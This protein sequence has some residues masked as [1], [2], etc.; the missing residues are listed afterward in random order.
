MVFALPNTEKVLTQFLSR[1]S[2][3]ADK[4][5]PTIFER[6]WVQ[7]L[8]LIHSPYRPAP[9]SQLWHTWYHR[10]SRISVDAAKTCV[11]PISRWILL[12]CGEIQALTKRSCSFSANKRNSVPRRAFHSRDF[13][14]QRKSSEK[15][16]NEK[17]PVVTTQWNCL[18]WRLSALLMW[19]H[20]ERFG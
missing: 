2:Q 13:S 4:R 11:P 6:P 12:P 20:G 14:F 9:F 18:S 15:W 19:A 17:R 1:H 10:F 16:A 3:L 7:R 5:V 8:P